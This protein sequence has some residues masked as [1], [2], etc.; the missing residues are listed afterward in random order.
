MIF[1][2]KITKSKSV[3]IQKPYFKDIYTVGEKKN[4]YI[5]IIKQL[6]FLNSVNS[7]IRRHINHMYNIS[8]MLCNVHTK[9]VYYCW[10]I[11]KI[12]EENT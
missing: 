7:A 3:D 12:M 6:Y 1:T 11:V 8:N 9:H 5:Y 4:I 2:S 10:F